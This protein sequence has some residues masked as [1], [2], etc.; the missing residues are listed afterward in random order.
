MSHRPDLLNVETFLRCSRNIPV[1][2]P[3]TRPTMS[4]MQAVFFRQGPDV[5]SHQEAAQRDPHR[6]SARLARP[7][8][9]RRLHLP[10][11]PMRKRRER[12]A[13]PHR[14]PLRLPREGP[15]KSPRLTSVIRSG[16]PSVRLCKISEGDICLADHSGYNRIVCAPNTG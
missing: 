11:K 9:R 10:G 8:D 3:S 12:E 14:Q 1:S 7:G 16:Y 5:L 4:R 13:D 2:V 15:S 6:L